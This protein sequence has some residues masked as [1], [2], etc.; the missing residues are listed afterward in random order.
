LSARSKRSVTSIHML[1]CALVL[2]GSLLYARPAAAVVSC[3]CA[4]ARENFCRNRFPCNAVT[5]VTTCLQGTCGNCGEPGETECTPGA[6]LSTATACPTDNNPCTGDFCNGAGACA[7]TN[8]T[9]GTVCDTS[10]IALGTCCNAPN[11]CSGGKVCPAPGGTCACP[12]ETYACGATCIASGS[13]CNNPNNCPAPMGGN[14]T[15]TCAAAGGACSFTCNG[16][17]K[18]CGAACI[19]NAN[20]CVNADCPDDAANHRAGVCTAGGCAYQCEAGYK[21]CGA[22][23]I[24][25]AAC[26][27]NSECVTPPNSCYKT[28]GTCSAGACTYPLNNGAACNADS[29]ACTPNDKCSGGTC[30]ADTANQVVC[31]RRECH[32]VPTCNTTTGNCDDSALPDVPTPASC[33]GNGCSA[34]TGSCTAGTCSSAPKDCSALDNSCRVGVCDPTAAIGTPCGSTNKMNGLSC[35]VADKCQLSPACSGG[36]CIGSPKACSPSGACRVAECNGTTGD[37]EETVAPVGTPCAMPGA[38]TQNAVCDATGNCGGDPVPDGS[39][40][41]HQDCVTAACV[42]EQC[43]C[44]ASP[45]FGAD[46]QPGLPGQD[47]DLGAGTAAD[48]GGCSISSTRQTASLAG[49][50]GLM[51]LF[52]LT[53]LARRRLGAAR[54]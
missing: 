38:C 33:G 4:P 48:E 1:S 11:S 49:S 52:L 25:V 47:A 41:E 8:T 22:A 29:N 45:D 27:A 20:C 12:A 54:R 16:G 14:G 40:C 28:Q 24:P 37:C 13:C 7:H 23:C 18:A 39:P 46:P 10:C 53:R 26:C 21:A 32:T 44:L 15:G 50:L 5:C 31:T 30:V 34:T 17:Y 19:P 51:L 3:A 36:A 9:G 35:T 2:V 43:V 42:T 6:P